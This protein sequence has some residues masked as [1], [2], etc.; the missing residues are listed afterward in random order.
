MLLSSLVVL[1]A[2]RFALALPQDGGEERAPA[3]RARVN[4]QAG[5]AAANPTSTSIDE[6]LEKWE[7]QSAKLKTLDVKIYRI[8][9]TPAWKEE[10]HF[11]GRAVFKSPQFAYL[12]FRKI[13]T[14]PNAK[15]ELGA[16]I[17]SKTGKRITAPHETIICGQ[18]EVWQYLF[19]VKQIYIY[20]LSKEERQRAL[21][22]GP[23]PFL[24]NMRAAEA[25]KRYHM[26][27]Q[28]EDERFYTLAIHPRLQEDKESFKAALVV[29]E[30]QYLLPARIFLISPDNKSSKDFRL[31]VINPNQTVNERIFQGVVLRGWKVIRNPDAQGRPRGNAAA[32]PGQP[33]LRPRE[34][35]LPQRR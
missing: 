6:L 30:R 20:P 8:D 2:S 13:K 16:V 12:D 1:A 15:G 4:A 31:E 5:D 34:S 35:D 22:E 21:D 7:R 9:R 32:A 23:L 25:K 18:K 27:L 29:L 17:D 33:A 14:A 26:V 11:E 28:R 19:N 3:P 24:F 10:D